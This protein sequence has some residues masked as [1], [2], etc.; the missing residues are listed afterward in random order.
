M[1]F[2]E[3][4]IKCIKFSREVTRTVTDNDQYPNLKQ[5]CLYVSKGDNSAGNEQ[6]QTRTNV[7]HIDTCC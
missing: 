5:Q 6:R 4:S 1:S 3:F 7:M 2:K